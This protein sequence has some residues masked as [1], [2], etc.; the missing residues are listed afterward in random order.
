MKETP[1]TISEWGVE[2]FGYPKNIETI[3]HRMLKECKE[4]EELMGDKYK[5]IGT[6]YHCERIADECADIYIVMCQ[7]MHTLGY[8]LHACVDHKMEINR[9]RKW[10]LNGDGTAQHV[11]E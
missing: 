7:V 11:K 8:D 4:L 2:T 6:V 10:K 1:K 9:H 3:V 5:N